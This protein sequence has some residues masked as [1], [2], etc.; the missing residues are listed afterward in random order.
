VELVWVRILPSDLQL[1]DGLTS[2][3]VV[4]LLKKEKEK[5]ASPSEVEP[6]QVWLLQQ[7]ITLITFL[8]T[9][10]EYLTGVF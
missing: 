6:C 7:S 5:R 10:T 2:D 9:M 1:L 8:V 4:L 3:L